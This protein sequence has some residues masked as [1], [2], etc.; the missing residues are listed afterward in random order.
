MKILKGKKT[1]IL[2][3]QKMENHKPFIRQTQALPG[4]PTH[5]PPFQH[6]AGTPG[7]IPQV[8][9]NIH[10]ASQDGPTLCFLSGTT[11]VKKCS[12]PAVSIIK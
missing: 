8:G 3:H 4:G 1:L 2:R 10:E 12:L 6:P 9:F 7:R 5:L 11:G